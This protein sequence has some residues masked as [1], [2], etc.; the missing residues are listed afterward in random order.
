VGFLSEHEAA[1]VE[2]ATARLIPGP[3]DDPAE[4]GSPGAR[5]AGVVGYVDGLLSA[6]DVDPPRI[7]AGGPFSARRGGPG[8]FV[9]LSP[10]QERFWRP[11]VAELGAR[12]RA[13]VLALD[14]AAG[15]DFSSAPPDVQDRVLAEDATGFRDLLFDHAIEGWLAPPEYGGNRALG[16]WAAIGFAGDVCP[17]GFADDAVR[18]GDGPDPYDATGVRAAI[19]EIVGPAFG[20]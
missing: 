9:P 7:H 4:A 10:V 12:Y 3:D 1:V 15:G 16:G 6:F 14:G 11:H 8:G 19:L 20:G 2:A 13:G 5:E 17:D 18:D